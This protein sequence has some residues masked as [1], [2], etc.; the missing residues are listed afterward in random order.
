MNPKASWA[1]FP[2]SHLTQA[3][4]STRYG[5]LGEC[6]QDLSRL[7]N[8]SQRCAFM[9]GRIALQTL[10]HA[11]G[12]KEISIKPQNPYGFL[13]L[14]DAQG[15]L[16]QNRY[17]SISHNEGVAVAALSTLPVGVD[18]EKRNRKA[19][20]VVSKIASSNEIEKLGLLSESF[21]KQVEDP[22]LFL[23][24]GKE[25]FSKALGLG[26]RK[27]IQ[28][29]EIHWKGEP[30]FSGKTDLETPISMQDPTLFFF[31]EQDCLVAICT[32]K[33]GSLLKP[34]QL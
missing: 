33:E 10:L 19:S 8:E 12:L 28:N 25:A 29:L 27:G 14:Q 32:E 16:L 15:Q 21:R 20:S 23:W 13:Q 30:P 3:V 6:Q 24:T 26:L 34:L 31:F 7:R 22:F 5:E 11:E 2:F 18:I 1:F 17:C 4:L 9:A